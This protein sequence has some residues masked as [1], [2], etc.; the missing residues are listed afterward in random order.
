M[1]HLTPDS[2]PPTSAGTLTPAE[3]DA[4]AA[5]VAAMEDDAFEDEVV[6]VTDAAARSQVYNR[7]DDKAAILQKEARRRPGGRALYD[8]GHARMRA[9]VRVERELDRQLNGLGGMR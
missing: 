4:Y 9:G 3:A 1:T 8:R 5:T 7:D 2:E 6:A